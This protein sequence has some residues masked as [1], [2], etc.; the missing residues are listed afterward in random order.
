MS[1]HILHRIHVSPAALA[2]GQAL[3]DGSVLAPTVLDRRAS[4]IG[5]MIA[6]FDGRA[7]YAR[8]TLGVRGDAGLQKAGIVTPDC[9][10]GASLLDMV[11]EDGWSGDLKRRTDQAGRACLR[12][13]AEVCEAV[14][15]LHP[16]APIAL[17][18]GSRSD[19]R[20]PFLPTYREGQAEADASNP[21]FGRGLA[22]ASALRR[23]LADELIV[24]VPASRRRWTV[25]AREVFDDFMGTPP[26]HAY[27]LLL[28]ARAKSAPIRLRAN[29]VGV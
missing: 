28:A 13:P 12:P 26:R 8:Y 10:D 2:S 3:E 9:V 18:R 22:V 29:G 21:F 7:V 6:E 14:S 16:L 24:H 23:V 4:I 27:Q 1:Q 5:E 11:G 25:Y 15:F 17:V 20:E 19:G